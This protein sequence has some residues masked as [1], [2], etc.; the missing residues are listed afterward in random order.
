MVREKLLLF[1]AEP[2]PELFC[3]CFDG[4]E[5]LLLCDA[6]WTGFDRLWMNI[7]ALFRL[8][9]LLERIDELSSL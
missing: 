4:E 9:L 3:E 1:A 2:P 8:P 5:P 6:S 7:G